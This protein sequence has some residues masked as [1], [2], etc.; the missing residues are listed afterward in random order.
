MKP[1]LAFV[2]GSL[3]PA[4]AIFCLGGNSRA[5]LVAGCL[6][7]VIPALLFARKVG[8]WLY[9]VAD[10]TDGVRGVCGRAGCNVVLL[11]RS[12]ISPARPLTVVRRGPKTNTTSA[13]NTTLEAN[14]LETALINLQ[15]PKKQAKSIAQKLGPGLDRFNEAVNMARRT[16]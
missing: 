4:I 15:V 3:V 11:R 14:E 12:D 10:A 13:D 9:W 8:G 1:A 7:A 16:A 2:S 5:C 6:T